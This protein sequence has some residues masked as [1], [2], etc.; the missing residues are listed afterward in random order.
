[1]E[2][3]FNIHNLVKVKIDLKNP[4]L[5]KDVLCQLSEFEI[6]SCLTDEVFDVRIFDYQSRPKLP[7]PLVVSKYYY[8]QSGVID[9]PEEMFCANLVSRP[10]D[11]YCKHFALP[12]NFLIGLAFMR[13]N[14]ALM[15]AAAVSFDDV[16][17]LFPAFGGVGKTTAIAKIID[18][19]GKLFGDDLI[20]VNSR[21]MFAYPID[22]SV[23]PYHLK[24][25]PIKSS[26]VAGKLKMAK[27]LDSVAGF[28]AKFD[29]LP[30][31]LAKKAIGYLSPPLVNVPPRDIFGANC[32]ARRGVPQ[33]ILYL[34]RKALPGD[35]IIVGKI[36]ASDLAIKAANIM[37]H[38]W[39]QAMRIM[40]VYSALSGFSMKKIFSDILS[41]Y[42]E[43]FSRGD[44]YSLTIPD[45]ITDQKYQ[46]ELI[47]LMKK[48]K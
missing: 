25:L 7:C 40:Y 15:H 26:F 18:H 33:K 4:S 35:E 6:F 39:N 42:E 37:F 11:V 13:K 31:Q 16:N 44:C 12:V 19:G 27:R 29:F 5:M 30:V 45:E 23:Y 36:T 46:D 48:I 38:E 8:Y 24:V 28:L 17:Y 2:K 22:F 3:I 41:M 47:D 9:I 10:I 43:I 34:E 20:I 1:M 32:L 21:E 14:H